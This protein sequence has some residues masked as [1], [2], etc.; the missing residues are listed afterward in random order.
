VQGV[1]TMDD[2]MKV[3]LRRYG[4]VED[5]NLTILFGK[6]CP[7]VIN[8]HAYREYA[9]SLFCDSCR[10]SSWLRLLSEALS[11]LPEGNARHR[12]G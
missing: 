9:M 11:A 6:V 1:L 3:L 5:Q 12:T 8:Q 4:K 10:V 7:W 2:C